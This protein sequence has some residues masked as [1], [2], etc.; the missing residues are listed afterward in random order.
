MAGSTNHTAVVV[1][2]GIAGILAAGA[3]SSFFDRVVVVERDRISANPEIRKG[4]PQASHVHVL[5]DRG[6]SVAESLLPGTRDTLIQAGAVPISAGWDELIYDGSQ[7]Q[8]QREFGII[9]LSQS[10]PVLEWSLRHCL[11]QFANVEVRD[12]TTL[13]TIDLDPEGNVT[14]VQLSDISG[15]QVLDSRL[16]VDA[17]GRASKSLRWLN[18]VGVGSLDADEIWIG[19]SYVS[20]IFKRSPEYFGKPNAWTVRNKEPLC[21]GVVRPIENDQ[22]IFTTASYFDDIPPTDLE[23]LLVYLKGFSNPRLYECVRAG[24][25]EGRLRVY[26]TPTVLV[27]RFDKLDR[28]PAGYLP[29]GDLIAHL[30]PMGGQGMSVAALHADLIR[31]LLT[32]RVN[33]GLSLNDLS[34]RFAEKAVAISS[35]AWRIFAMRDLQHPSTKGKRPDNFDQIK[36]I[37][38]GIDRLIYDDPDIHHLTL[39][40]RNMLAEPSTLRA[41]E[42]V[43][44]A[45]AIA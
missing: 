13:K 4:T 14:G 38:R 27:R 41:P 3:L 21:G 10:R 11:S 22:W 36:K 12:R 40:V 35:E 15:D 25:L 20:G 32:E 23:D 8:P 43:K 26:R 5:L 29:V 19:L 33:D 39:K 1:G 18:E 34:R 45:L 31:A 6:L 30:N 17:S 28:L 44:R 24:T 7:W 16:V 2:A 9:N 37:M 42:I